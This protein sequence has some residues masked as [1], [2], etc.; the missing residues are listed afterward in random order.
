MNSKEYGAIT[1]KW[2]DSVATKHPHILIWVRNIFTLDEKKR[3]GL[4]CWSLFFWSLYIVNTTLQHTGQVCYLDPHLSPFFRSHL[5]SKL[6]S[7]FVLD[8]DDCP[9][10]KTASRWRRLLS[11]CRLVIRLRVGRPLFNLPCLESFQIC[12]RF[13]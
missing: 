5:N 2:S 3:F 12:A 1:W 8:S 7:T 10:H 6:T 11:H 9:I 4:P 13:V